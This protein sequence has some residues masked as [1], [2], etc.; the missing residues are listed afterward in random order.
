MPLDLELAN[1]RFPDLESGFKFIG[2][3]FL[4]VNIL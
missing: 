1:L 3:L 2:F 4:H